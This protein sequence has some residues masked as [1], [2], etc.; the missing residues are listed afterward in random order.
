MYLNCLCSH[1]RTDYTFTLYK[2]LVKKLYKTYP[3]FQLPYNNLHY[4][5]HKTQIHKNFNFRTGFY[6][7]FSSFPPTEASFV[8]LFNLCIFLFKFLLLVLTLALD[9]SSTA[10]FSTVLI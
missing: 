2:A 3:T 6:P 4:T 7:A 8:G 5:Q 9:R 10:I 1:I